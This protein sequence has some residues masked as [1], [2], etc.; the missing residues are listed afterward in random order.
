MMK[1][2]EALNWA[3]SFLRNE[4]REERAAELLLQYHL[5]KKRTDFFASMR[6]VIS[7]EHYQ[8]F[9]KSVRKH[10]EGTPVQHIIGFE[11]F[12]GRLFK[13]NR[14]V[15]IPRPETEELIEGVLQRIAEHELSSTS[16][17]VDVGTGSGIIAITLKLE[18]PEANVSAVDIS[19]DALAI[20]KTNAETLGADVQF[21]HGDLL[22]P[23]VDLNQKVD[24]VVSNPPYIPEKDINYLSDV[25][26]EHDPMLALVGGQDGLDLYRE[27][28]NQLPSVLQK[29]G[30]VGMEI[31]HGQGE[32]VANLLKDAFPAAEVEV[33][34][35]INKKER[36]VFAV[37]K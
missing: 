23:L 21:R 20:A 27:L 2:Y 14:D 24:I 29:P 25:V 8:E 6:E 36:M 37:I 32:D 19:T 16:K 1:V 22:K 34:H 7:E 28:A 33:V 18:M 12:Y 17:I 15:L 4:G 3:S 30:L 35:D 11:E 10:A 9:E 31:G 26:K 5:G 13:V